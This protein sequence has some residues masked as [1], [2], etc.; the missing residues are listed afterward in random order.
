MLL[1]RLVERDRDDARALGHAL[2]GAQVE[3]ARRPSASCRSR[4]AARR[5]SRSRSPA[6]RPAR[7][8][9]RR[10]GRARPAPVRSGC[11]ERKTLFFSSPIAR[12]LERGG[13]LH[14]HEREHLEE[15]GDH[16]VAVGAGLLVEAGAAARSRASR[17]RRSARARC[18]GGSRSA[19]RGRWRTGRRGCSAPLPCPGSGRS[20]RSGSSR[21]AACSASL[22]SL[23]A[24]EVGAERLLHDDRARARPARPS[25]SVR[26]HRRRGR[27][28]DA[29]VV[30]PARRRPRARSSA[31][32]TACRE[33]LAARRWLD[34]GEPRGELRPSPRRGRRCGRTRRSAAARTPRNSSSSIVVERRARRCGTRGISPAWVEVQQP[35][36]Q[37]AAR[38]V[39]RRA[40]EH[41]DVR[42]ERGDGRGRHV[43][44]IMRRH[45]AHATRPRPQSR[46]IRW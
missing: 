26:D 12:G 14:R 29:Q 18:A 15:V 25:R 22:S 44:G 20:G 13:R 8:G 21:K 2:A 39:A 19:R 23:R 31:R 42:L 35:R 9:S 45:R 6:R 11:S 3:R 41:D 32:P 4:T 10:T 38:Q 24:R 30:Q 37:L 5:T 17:A 46:E 34:V 28:R 7:R 33:R 36:E 16:H 43:A 40:E 1:R 27:G